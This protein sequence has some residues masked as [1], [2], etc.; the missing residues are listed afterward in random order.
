M[1]LAQK[2]KKSSEG[3]KELGNAHIYV[4][5]YVY[6]NTYVYLNVCVCV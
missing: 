2:W 3:N 1:E 6:L 4:F 5:I